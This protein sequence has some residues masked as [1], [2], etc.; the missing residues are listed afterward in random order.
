[1]TLF[2]KKKILVLGWF[3]KGLYIYIYIYIKNIS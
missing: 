3:G 2:I 1:M